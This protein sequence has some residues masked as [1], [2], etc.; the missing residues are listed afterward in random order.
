MAKQMTIGSHNLPHYPKSMTL[1]RADKSCAEKLTWDSVA[2]F[3]WPPSI[4]GKGIECR[5]DFLSSANFASLDTI[6]QANLPATWTSGAPGVTDTYTVEITGLNGDYIM[7]GLG[8]TN[9]VMRLLI[10]A[11]NT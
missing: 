6:F 7:G 4:I 1:V 8:R 3:S 2:F 5:W 9:V 11:V 10:M